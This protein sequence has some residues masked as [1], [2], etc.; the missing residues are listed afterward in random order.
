MFIR[1]DG[2]VLSEENHA[3]QVKLAG[4][5]ESVWVDPTVKRAVENLNRRKG[6]EA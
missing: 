4:G 2:G 3:L 1:M 6:N 5:N